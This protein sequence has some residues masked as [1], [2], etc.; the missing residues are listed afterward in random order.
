MAPTVKQLYDE[1]ALRH[2]KVKDAESLR[3]RLWEQRR[4]ILTELRS[5]GEPLSKLGEF[6]GVHRTVIHRLTRDRSGKS[7]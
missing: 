4:E 3:D 6:I 1:L 7:D 5:R 2:S